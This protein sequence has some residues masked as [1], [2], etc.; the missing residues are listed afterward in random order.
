MQI[1]ITFPKRDSRSLIYARRDANPD[2]LPHAKALG[3]YCQN[4]LSLSLSLSLSHT[5]THTHTHL[6]L[7]LSLSLS[8]THTHTHYLSLSLSLSLTHTHTP[9]PSC[10]HMKA[11]RTCEC[12]WTLEHTCRS[13]L[14]SRSV[15]ANNY[16]MHAE[17]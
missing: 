5:H 3:N 8:H 13:K 10:R 7:S 2:Y 12:T 16:Y 6:S 17:M 1:K 14:H 11:A 9:T 15:R 4:V